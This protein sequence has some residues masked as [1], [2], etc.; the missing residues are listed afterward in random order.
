MSSDEPDCVADPGFDGRTMHEALHWASA[1]AI[2]RG[3]RGGDPP[4]AAARCARRRDV[5]SSGAAIVHR[6][7]RP[8]ALLA[9]E[10]HRNTCRTSTCHDLTSKVPGGGPRL[11]TLAV[12]ALGCSCLVA[13]SPCS[14]SAQVERWTLERTIT[15][16]D[17]ERP[18]TGIDLGARCDRSRRAPVRDATP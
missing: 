13:A 18:G 15:I 1:V 7:H 17:H 5:P 10:H 11:A 12:A 14:G 4:V 8:T 16:G 9:G 2:G 6:R 3:W